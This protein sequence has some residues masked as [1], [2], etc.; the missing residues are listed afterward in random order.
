MKRLKNYSPK[1]V[2]N[3]SNTL[4]GYGLRVALGGAALDLLSEN[5]KINVKIWEEEERWHD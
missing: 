3:L 5:I 4:Q 2:S 1:K